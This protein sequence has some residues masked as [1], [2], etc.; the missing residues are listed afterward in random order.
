ML[1][2]HEE[3]SYLLGPW[4]AVRSAKAAEQIESAERKYFVL[5]PD[6]F[7]AEVRVTVEEGARAFRTAGVGVALDHLDLVL[8]TGA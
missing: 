7:L 6:G 5:M 1:D 4:G 2:E 8:Q 3:I